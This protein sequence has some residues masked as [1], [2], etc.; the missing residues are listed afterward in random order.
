MK[1]SIALVL[2]RPLILILLSECLAWSQAKQEHAPIIDMHLH[3]LKVSEFA[4]TMGTQ[5]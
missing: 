1:K 2:C 4:L 5:R 3:A